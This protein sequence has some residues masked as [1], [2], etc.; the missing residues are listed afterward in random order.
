MLGWIYK[1]ND[2]FL[3]WFSEPP[4]RARKT[5]D[6]TRRGWGHDYTFRPIKGGMAGHMLGWGQG[7]Q[8]GDYLIIENGPNDSSRYMVDK[9]SYSKETQDMWTAKVSFAP[10][11]R[12][13]HSWDDED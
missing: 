7:I 12:L 1:I 4:K 11:T 5:H 6:Y 10:R 3:K 2:K 13:Q 8:E 9:I